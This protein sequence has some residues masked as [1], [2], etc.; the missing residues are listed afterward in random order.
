MFSFSVHCELLYIIY[1]QV[2]VAFVCK[3]L[4]LVF[5]WFVFVFKFNLVLS[6]ELDLG[7]CDVVKL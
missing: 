7:D 4:C 2:G 6:P 5:C 1:S 3:N